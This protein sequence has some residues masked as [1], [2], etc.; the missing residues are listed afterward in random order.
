LLD[1]TL[2]VVRRRGLRQATIEEITELAGYS[3]GAF[4]A[5]F[6]S[7]EEALLEVLELRADEQLDQFRRSALSARSETAAIRVITGA[8]LPETSSGRRVLKYGDLMTALHHD[9]DLRRRGLELLRRGELVL[10]EVVEQLCERRGKPAPCSR[11]ELGA[12]VVTLL[13]GVATRS[14]LD[15]D[16]DATA[17]FRSWLDLV[18]GS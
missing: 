3:R 12:V 6:E 14:L 18:L 2:G 16:L 4:Y 15:P 11:A 13:D 8:L 10:G 17:M 5:H 1:A 9:D 7:K